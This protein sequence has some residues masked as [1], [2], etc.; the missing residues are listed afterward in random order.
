[1]FCNSCGKKID[2]TYRYCPICGA[3]QGSA[4][5]DSL[6]SQADEELSEQKIS[7]EEDANE[8]PIF[9]GRPVISSREQ[10]TPQD[11]PDPQSPLEIP[12]NY[13]VWAILSTILCCL[14]L[15]AIAIY[16]SSRVTQNVLQGDYKAAYGSAD[17]ALTL[18]VISAIVGLFLI[19]G[20][21]ALHQGSPLMR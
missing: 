5:N 20:L 17:T 19:L 11:Y 1:M 8:S 16:Y 13:M 4:K 21:A 12:N 2:D 3:Q 10:I 7:T 15:G 6:E 9:G 18:S 14:P